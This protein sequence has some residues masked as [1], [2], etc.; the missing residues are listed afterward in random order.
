MELT[1]DVRGNRRQLA[2]A[3][4][5]ADSTTTDIVY[6]GSKGSGKSFLGCSLILADALMYPGTDYFIARKTLKDLRT[7]TRRSITEVL[8]LWGLG[9]AY[10]TYNGQDDFYRFHNGSIVRLVGCEYRPTDPLFARFGGMQC[11]R[12]WIEEAGEVSEQAKNN[13]SATIGRCRNEM[14]GLTPKLLQTCNPSANYLYRDYYKPFRE[15]T[16]PPWRAFIQALP[17]DNKMLDNGYLDN[18]SKVLTTDQRKRLLLGMW[19]FD[20]NPD[21][22]VTYEAVTDVFSNSGTTGARAISADLALHGRDRCVIFYWEGTTARLIYDST[23]SEAREIEG[24]ISTTAT[25]YRVGRSQIVADSDGLGGYLSSYLTGIKE[26]HGGAAPLD[27][28]F[29]TIKAQCA[30]KLAELINNR[31]LRIEGVDDGQRDNITSELMQLVASNKADSRLAL[32]GKDEQ[33]A[34][35]GHSPDYLDALLMGMWQF[36]QPPA[37]GITFHSHIQ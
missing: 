26:F 15:G 9:E 11:T 6:G 7:L 1:F 23:H 12:G 3:K 10:Y 33:K 2:V 30:F 17:Q 21:L 29:A 8:T 34:V 22:L 31:T 25:T 14:Y 32:V 4:L 28:K 24:V 20:D 18:L 13:L 5:W 35:L 27:K 36:I 37:K 19:E 16:L